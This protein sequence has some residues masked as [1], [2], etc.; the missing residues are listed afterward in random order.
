[1][2]I[3]KKCLSC[4]QNSLKEI[5][6]L[7]SH[8]FADRFVPKKKIHYN[9]P[10]YPLV[11]DLCTKCKFI[12]SKFKTNP[13]QRYIEVDYFHTSSNSNY[14]KNHWNKFANFLDKK[15]ELKNKKVLEIGSNDGYLC[16]MLNKKGANSLGVDASSFIQNSPKEKS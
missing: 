13:K 1:M 4:K 15:F 3:R 6:N 5:I 10:S 9:D 7:G 8:S 14:A 2:K 12:Q 16:E 11:L